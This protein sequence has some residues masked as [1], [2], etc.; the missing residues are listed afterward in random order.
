MEHQSE[1][2]RVIKS[3]LLKDI[4]CPICGG[5]VYI[6]DGYGSMEMQEYCEIDRNH[7]RFFINLF[8]TTIIVDGKKFDDSQAG[9][10]AACK[11]IEEFVKKRPL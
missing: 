5:P 8:A 2:E 4:T 10:R 7:Y 9:F 11:Y 1:E 6:D 3:I